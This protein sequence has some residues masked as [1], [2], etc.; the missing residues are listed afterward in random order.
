M[1]L[2]MLKE[3]SRVE[4][5]V[6]GLMRAKHVAEAEKFVDGRKGLALEQISAE[7]LALAS[8]L[9]SASASASAL[10]LALAWISKIRERSSD[11]EDVDWLRVDVASLS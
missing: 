6:G 10:T 3:N 5:A 9:A 4:M 8:A 2:G 7:A 1:Q 11:I